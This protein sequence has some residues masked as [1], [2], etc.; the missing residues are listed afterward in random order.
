MLQIWNREEKWI[1]IHFVLPPPYSLQEGEISQW[2]AIDIPL[3][4]M[5]EQGH[6]RNFHA[7]MTLNYLDERRN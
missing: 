1:E 6:E 3:L 7:R 4:R 2:M 5:Y